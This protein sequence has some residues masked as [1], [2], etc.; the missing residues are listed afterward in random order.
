MALRSVLPLPG[1]EALPGVVGVGGLVAV[2]AI[3]VRELEKITPV[4]LQREDDMVHDVLG[5]V[6]V[7]TIYGR[8]AVFTDQNDVVLGDL[9]GLLPD[10]LVK[11][12]PPPAVP[13]Y[14][15]VDPVNTP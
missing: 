5:P 2:V 3:D 9:A 11:E 7:Y 13:M 6:R 14:G 15:A 1:A 10:R 4:T 8:E 12:P